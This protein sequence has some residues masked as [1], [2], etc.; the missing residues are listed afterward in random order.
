MIVYFFNR[1]VAVKLEGA[2]Y[3]RVAD[4]PPLERIER[5]P[6]PDQVIMVP[7]QHFELPP[8]Y[9]NT[10]SKNGMSSRVIKRWAS[11]QWWKMTKLLQAQGI[12]VTE[13]RARKGMFD[14]NYPA[15]AGLVL[16]PREL[17]GN[18]QFVSS[19]LLHL[20][21]KLEPELMNP[22][23]R[24]AGYDMINLFPGHRSLL[25][26]PYFE[27]QANVVLVP[28]LN[29][30]FGNLSERCGRDA[31]E[32]L[33]EKCGLK[34]FVVS[35]DPYFYDLDTALFFIPPSAATP[36]PFAVYAQEAFKRHELEAFE[37]LFDRDHRLVQ[38]DYSETR[39]GFVLNSLGLPKQAVPTVLTNNKVVVFPQSLKDRGIKVLQI[40][41]SEIHKGGGSITCSQLRWYGAKER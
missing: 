34:I 21:R 30:A 36:L 40:P 9:T 23:F 14:A 19:R 28:G 26:P 13:V 38:Y 24:R 31:L 16:P 1:R 18:P 20:H 22:V 4:I 27:G 39:H 2:I 11:A 32:R 35:T 33:A 29:F 37:A 17:G 8:G 7:P 12:A 5:V 6:Y 41:F 3:T 15:N 10:M 25:D